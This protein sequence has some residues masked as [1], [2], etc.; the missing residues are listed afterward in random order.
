MN[1]EIS[2]VNGMKSY[3]VNG[4]EVVNSGYDVSCLVI[5]V[6]TD[7]LRWYIST[8][9]SHTN[10]EVST[11]PSADQ[12]ER[13]DFLNGTAVVKGKSVSSFYS[14]KFIGLNSENGLPLFDDMENE[15]ERLYGATKYDVFT[16]VLEA[17]GQ[18]EPT[19]F[20]GLSTT[21]NYKRWRLNAS[22]T[23]SLGAKTRLFKLYEDNS[24]RIRPENNLNKV[25]LK[26]WQNQGDEGYTNIPAF[27]SD[28]RSE[29][30]LSHWSANTSGQVPEIAS[31]RWEMY[32]YSNIRVVSANY[33][34]CTNLGFTY[35]FD[36][37][38]WGISLLDVSASMSNPFI[39]TSSK[40]KGQTPIQSGFTEVQLSERPTF[41]LGVN[42]IF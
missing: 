18:R 13:F 26:R 5:P 10:N 29:S 35:S 21:V 15:K 30:S 37:R 39:L 4:G 32:N 28:G 16:Q 33:L 20:G 24:A 3:V 40:L 9:F 2:G 1:K 17:S 41:S 22:F 11:L 27:I 34:K 14:Y 6:R 36:A 38:C 19:I 8:S 42:V 31:T 23:Y 7:D 12:Y 25:F